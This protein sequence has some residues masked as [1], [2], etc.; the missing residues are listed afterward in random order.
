M[1]RIALAISSLAVSV[2]AFSSSGNLDGRSYCRTVVS[3]GSF[4]QPKGVRQH[5]L[6][7]SNGSAV[8][9]ANT[10][11]GNPPEY[12]AY[13]VTSFHVIFGNSE[14]LISN[15]G[16]LLKTVRGSSRSGTVFSLQRR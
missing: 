6:N 4:G 8:D 11:F 14:Y 15:D 2:T 13:R 1:K 3:D 12:F 16:T 9:N 5:C 10:L 7:F